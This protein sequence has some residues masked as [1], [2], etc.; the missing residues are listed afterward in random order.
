MKRCSTC[1]RTYDDPSL[2]FCIDDGTPLT[3]VERDDNTTVVRPRN[4]EENTED[5]DWNAVAY[6]PPSPYVPPGTERKRRRMWPWVVGIV[7][8]FILGILALSVVGFVLQMRSW[9][10][11]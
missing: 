6:Q 5:N 10:N 1:N 2:S 9:R 3:R 7:G 4:T 8:A 11:E